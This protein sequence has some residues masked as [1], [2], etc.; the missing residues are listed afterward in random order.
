MKKALIGLSLILL[1]GAALTVYEITKP[2]ITVLSGKERLSTPQSFRP[3]VE[4]TV[5]AQTD[6]T[7]LRLAYTAEQVIFNWERN[8][9]QLRV[10][11]GPADGLH[12]MGA[13]RIPTGQYVTVKW[14]VT[15]T[16]QAI[17]VDGGLRFEHEG[18]YPKLTGPL[19]SFRLMGPPSA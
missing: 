16:H 7:N 17:Y 3:P 2:A 18:D 12:K 4:I 19:Q 10:N 15:T 6:S 8:Q 1:A 11:G 5:V 9:S 13:G 14:V